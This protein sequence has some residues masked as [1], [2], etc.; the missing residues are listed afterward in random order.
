VIDSDSFCG[1]M[2]NAPRERNSRCER[3]ASLS[4]PN[5]SLQG[6]RY[7]LMSLHTAALRSKRAISLSARV[8][9]VFN[10][11]APEERDRTILRLPQGTPT[12]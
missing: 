9:A 10:E 2:F 6:T 7:S 3:S 11:D 4:R 8:S 1:D 5:T 12:P